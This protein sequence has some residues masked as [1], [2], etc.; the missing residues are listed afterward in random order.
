MYIYLW[1]TKKKTETNNITK[2]KTERKSKRE[3][4]REREY[5][6]NRKCIYIFLQMMEY[7]HFVKYKLVE[8]VFVCEMKLVH[9]WFLEN[10]TMDLQYKDTHKFNICPNTMKKYK[11]IYLYRSKVYS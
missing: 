1:K 4:R 5:R 3:G 8:C 11:F 10:I 7:T 9:L 6:L 2:S